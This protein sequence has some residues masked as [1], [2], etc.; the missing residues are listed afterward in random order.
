M[1]NTI[2]VLAILGLALIPEIGS[3]QT[4]G[5]IKKEKTKLVSFSYDMGNYDIEQVNKTRKANAAKELKR[6]K[7]LDSLALIRCKR[8]AGIIAQDPDF[9][10]TEFFKDQK[11]STEIVHN[12]NFTPENARFLTN[13]AGFH[14]DSLANLD[15]LKVRNRL[16]EGSFASPGVF[17]AGPGYDQS[18]S[19]LENRIGQDHKEYGSCYLAVFVYAKN[20]NSKGMV[21]Y[22]PTLVIIHYELF[23]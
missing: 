6:S 11:K 23:K 22:I 4:P 21:P 9:F 15:P 1:K 10:C 14:K 8:M 2:L 20:Y 12:Q 19:H 18:P 13:G 3:S 17:L 16:I 7:T 5:N